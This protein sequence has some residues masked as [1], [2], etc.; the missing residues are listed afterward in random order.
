MFTIKTVAKRGTFMEWKG[1]KAS[2]NVEDRRGKGGVIV[3]GGGIV[4][5]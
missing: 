5:C 2:R 4:C 3:A 1:R